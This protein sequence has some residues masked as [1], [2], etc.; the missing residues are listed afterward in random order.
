[1]QRLEERVQAADE[2]LAGARGEVKALEVLGLSPKDL[3]GLV[4]RM[5]G[6]AQRHGIEPGALRERLLHELEELETG[7]GLEALAAVKRHELAEAEQA[8]AKGQ[9][10]RQALDSALQQLR[11]QQAVLRTSIVQEQ[12]HVRKEIQTIAKIA[13]DAT[14]E[15]RQDMSNGVAEALLEVQ[16]LRNQAF[17]LG[18]E[19][20]RF[21]A[22]IEANEW[23]GT[24]ATLVKGDGSISAGDVRVVGLAV[25]RGVEGW[26]QQNKE[27]I[28][29]PFGLATRIGSIIEEL[30]RWKV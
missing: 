30:E 6:I 11:Q 15:L 21:E 5:G 3:T 4:Q 8:I 10:E 17:E 29:L 2:R 27:R 19:L 26:I 25:L 22:T 16:R 28:S 20:G 14:A 18:Q 23:L 9:Q 7:L 12:E 24:V 13:R 1:M